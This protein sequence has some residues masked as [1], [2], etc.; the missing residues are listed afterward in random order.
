MGRSVGYKPHDPAPTHNHPTLRL[1]RN[2]L[3]RRGGGWFWF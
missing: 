1:L 3:T 2:I